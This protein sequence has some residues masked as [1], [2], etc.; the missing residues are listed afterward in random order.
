MTALA[1]RS[2]P[3]RGPRGRRL[4]LEIPSRLGKHQQTMRHN[5]GKHTSNHFR[6]AAPIS[7][8]VSD[9]VRAP[10]I[11]C[12]RVLLFGIL[13]CA[14]RPVVIHRRDGRDGGRQRVHARGH[15]RGGRT[16]PPPRTH[17]PSGRSLHLACPAPGTRTITDMLTLPWPVALNASTAACC[18]VSVGSCGV[19]NWTVPTGDS[20]PEGEEEQPASPRGA[21]LPAR[22]AKAFLDVL[23]I[24]ATPFGDVACDNRSSRRCRGADFRTGE[25]TVRWSDRRRA[26]PASGLRVPR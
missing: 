15:L 4:P 9:N 3:V 20:G 19:Q 13:G 6:P 11:T 5:P 7:R 2:A 10:P 18:S 21:T 16:D 25:V 8:T 1:R 12:S 17:L 22:A 26:V 24:G 23:F 14:D